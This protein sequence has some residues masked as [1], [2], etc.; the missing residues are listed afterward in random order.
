MGSLK[1][2]SL[3]YTNLFHGSSKRAYR[4]VDGHGLTCMEAQQRIGHYIN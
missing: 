4:V 1:I 2:L 3:Q